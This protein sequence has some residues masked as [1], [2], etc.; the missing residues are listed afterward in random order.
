MEI[1]ERGNRVERSFHLNRERYHYEFKA[2][3]PRD[4]WHQYDTSQD[5]WDFG[6]WVHPGKRQIVTFAEGDETVVTC[7]DDA[8]LK[9]EL[10]SMAVFYGQPPP[11]F[12]VIDEHGRRTEVYDERPRID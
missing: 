7:P 11:A 1:N 9:A 10:D 4:G 3:R 5:T 6:V 2:C 12:H 8:R